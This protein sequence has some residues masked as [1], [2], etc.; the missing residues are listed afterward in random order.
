MIFEAY[1]RVQIVNLASRADRRR[2]M[3]GELRRMGVESDPRI[4]F[5][6]AVAPADAGNW[7][8]LG[9][10]G[11]YQSHLEILKEARERG[12][13]VLIL[14]DDCDFTDAAMTF[15][16][17]LG[18]DIFYGGFGATDYADLQRSNIQGSH[19]MG[20]SRDIIPRL[21]PF[22]EQLART[23]SPPPIDGAYVKFRRENADVTARFA[24]PQVAVQRQSPSDINPGRFDQNKLLGFGVGLLRRLNRANYR[25][26]KMMEGV[27][28]AEADPRVP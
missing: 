26:A 15:D 16:W 3:R 1:D 22:L 9:E 7:T 23:P 14:E 25:R 19:C 10:H 2:E 27:K 5:F 6:S 17:G 21:V 12:E 13:S 20:F 18:V 24:L 8:S 4:S 11:C 28:A